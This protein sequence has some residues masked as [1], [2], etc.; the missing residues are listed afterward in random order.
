M[1]CVESSSFKMHGR[2]E[3][4]WLVVKDEHLADG[5]KGMKDD[6]E[7]DYMSEAFICDASNVRPG[8]FFSFSF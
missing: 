6:E 7:E 2:M 1:A 4:E 8:F 5:D 3:E